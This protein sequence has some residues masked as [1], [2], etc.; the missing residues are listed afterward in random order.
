MSEEVVR[1]ERREMPRVRP[2]SDIVERE[3]GFHIYMDM[4]GV[5]RED[6]SIDLDKNEVQVSAPAIHGIG[7]EDTAGSSDGRRYTHVEFGSG[8]FS[9][10]FTLADNVD[11]ERI[12]AT[13]TDGVLDLF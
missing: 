6:L 8:V 3:D 13:L 2:A 4:P 12:K 10:S 5:R 11:R 1:E 9:R 7:L